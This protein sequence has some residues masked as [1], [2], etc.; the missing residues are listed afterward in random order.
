MPTEEFE[1]G[2]LYF[3]SKNDEEYKELGIGTIESNSLEAEGND[4]FNNMEDIYNETGF[5]AEVKI[6]VKKYTKK[7]FKKLLMSYGIQRND[8]E[9]FAIIAGDEKSSINRNNLGLI[10]VQ[11]INSMVNKKRKKVEK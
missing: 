7:R 4:K 10:M 5:T 3:K 9:I 6:K 8:A 2:K 1:K 11:A